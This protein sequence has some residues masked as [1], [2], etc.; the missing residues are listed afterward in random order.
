[1]NDAKPFGPFSRDEFMAFRDAPAGKFKAAVRKHDPLYGLEYEGELARFKVTIIKYEKVKFR[2]SVV[3]E[4][5]DTA[6]AENLAWKLFDEDRT[7]E[8][9]KW[10][11]RGTSDCD[12]AEVESVEGAP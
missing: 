7:H 4:A 1:M 6:T 12:D 3:V 5:P 10:V 9:F 11:E 2:G 8:Q